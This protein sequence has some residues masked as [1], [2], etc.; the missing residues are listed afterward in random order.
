M[1]AAKRPRKL[2]DETQERL[3]SCIG[4]SSASDRAVQSIW[5]K[6]APDADTVTPTTFKRYVSETLQPALDCFDRFALQGLEDECRNLHCKYG[7]VGSLS[8][9][10]DAQPG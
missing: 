2:T 4:T 6:A 5:N 9:E 10:T 3:K 1:R 8:W 7:K